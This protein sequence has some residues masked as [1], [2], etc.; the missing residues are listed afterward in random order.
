MQGALLQ[1]S[2]LSTIPATGLVCSS[3]MMQYLLARRP[4][5]IFYTVQLPILSTQYRAILRCTQHTVEVLE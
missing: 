5:S 1:S 4:G 2:G 3:E